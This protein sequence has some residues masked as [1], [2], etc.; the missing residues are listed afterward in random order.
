VSAI[1]SGDQRTINKS[2]MMKIKAP[3]MCEAFI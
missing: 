2:K 3:W 1:S